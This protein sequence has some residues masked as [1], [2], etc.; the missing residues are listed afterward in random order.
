MKDLVD[1]QNRGDFDQY[2][3]SLEKNYYEQKNLPKPPYEMIPEYPPKP[4]QTYK[5]K[6][7]TS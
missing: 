6:T 2:M 3:R 5:S 7:I 4:Y 1:F